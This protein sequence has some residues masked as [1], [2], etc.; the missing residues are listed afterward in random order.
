[1][2]EAGLRFAF[3]LS[4]F[5]KR[6]V[7]VEAIL[8]LQARFAEGRCHR[9]N[10]VFVEFDGLEVGEAP[11][12]FAE[13]RLDGDRAAIGG[14]AL[15]LLTDGLEIMPVACP[16][17]GL[18]RPRV[19]DLAVEGDRLLMTADAP[20]RRRLQAGMGEA[21]RAI[22]LDAFQLGDR[23][24]VAVLLVQNGGEIGPGGGEPRREFQSAAQQIL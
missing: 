23:V 19:E 17:P 18:A 12:R 5:A 7:E 6:E 21:V 4:R 20:Q 16:Q 9:R 10:I 14:D 8:V 22:M 24:G 3:V 15:R 1:M 11:P 2:A 13:R